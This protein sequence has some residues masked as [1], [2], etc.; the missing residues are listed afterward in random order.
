MRHRKTSAVETAVGVSVVMASPSS[1][2]RVILLLPDPRARGAVQD[3]W[4]L[5]STGGILECWVHAWGGG[6]AQDV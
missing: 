3:A 4:A 5:A 6:A 2:T 1:Q